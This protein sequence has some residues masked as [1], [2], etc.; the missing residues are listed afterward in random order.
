L[1]LSFNANLKLTPKEFGTWVM[2]LYDL[3]PYH[4]KYLSSTDVFIS[5]PLIALDSISSKESN[6][7]FLKNIG[8]NRVMNI[9]EVRGWIVV[10][11]DSRRA[12]KT[13]KMMNPEQRHI[14][15]CQISKLIL[16]VHIERYCPSNCCFGSVNTILEREVY[17]E[18]QRLMDHEIEPGMFRE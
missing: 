12:I 5:K 18:I 2:R 1:P 13:I 6:V 3:S 8:I 17:D 11:S 4:I 14:L 10:L 9:F 15:R 16:K 7:K